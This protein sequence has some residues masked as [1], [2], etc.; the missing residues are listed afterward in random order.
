MYA[1]NWTATSILQQHTVP[2]ALELEGTVS[3]IKH[4][5]GWG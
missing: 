2:C 4:L 1:H 3:K 5:I